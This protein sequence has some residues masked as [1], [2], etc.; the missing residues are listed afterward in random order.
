[1]TH[2]CRFCKSAFQT[3][4]LEQHVCEDCRCE[5]KHAIEIDPKFKFE[6][7]ETILKDTVCIERIAK[8]VFDVP[9]RQ[10]GIGGDSS[11]ADFFRKRNKANSTK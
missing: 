5:V 6:L 10:L 11:L 7:L 2:I 9:A 8:A 3:Q 4:D 1:M